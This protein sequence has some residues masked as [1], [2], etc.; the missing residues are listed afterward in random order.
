M[1]SLPGDGKI[2]KDGNFVCC[3]AAEKWDIRTLTA[4][5]DVFVIGNEDIAII[6]AIE[7]L[8][9]GLIWE[10]SIYK[11]TVVFSNMALV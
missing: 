9:E 8:A 10:I 1:T 5:E 3:K 4:V 11:C 6:Q 2:G 7:R